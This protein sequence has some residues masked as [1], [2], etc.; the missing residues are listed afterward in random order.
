MLNFI[1]R[2]QQDRK[3]IKS[4]PRKIEQIN[5]LL[6]TN[7]WGQPY[8]I[9]HGLKKG[10]YLI[11]QVENLDEFGQP[12]ISPASS[13][14]SACSDIYR[15]IRN[16]IVFKDLTKVNFAAKQKLIDKFPKKYHK[17]VNSLLVEL[18]A[19]EPDFDYNCDLK[20][21][22]E[23]EDDYFYEGFE[24]GE[25]W[26]FAYIIHDDSTISEVLRDERTSLSQFIESL[27]D[28]E[29]I[30]C[31]ATALKLKEEI[32]SPQQKWNKNNPETLRKSGLAKPV[33]EHR[34]YKTANPPYQFIPDSKLRSQIESA[35]KPGE[36]DQELL[37]RLLSKAL[38]Y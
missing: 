26:V 19:Y 25:D 13:L 27:F 37:T 7:W 30:C 9:N 21:Y 32:F 34:T 22:N 35:R 2:Y 6:K 5:E 11:V 15:C 20:L 33:L 10:E 29:R 38:E 12:T 1:E 14:S 16:N 8:R 24:A 36:S 31:W 4:L 17:L 23:V 28:T 3:G 18:Y